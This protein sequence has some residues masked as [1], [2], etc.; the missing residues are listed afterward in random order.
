MGLTGDMYSDRDRDIIRW[1]KLIVADILRKRGV[2][3]I[4]MNIFGDRYTKKD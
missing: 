4:M 1:K 3:V 2:E